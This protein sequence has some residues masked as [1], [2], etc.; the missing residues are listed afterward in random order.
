MDIPQ[1]LYNRKQFRS[2]QQGL[3]KS[4]CYRRYTCPHRVYAPTGCFFWCRQFTAG[5][6]SCRL[7]H[8]L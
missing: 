4:I 8:C 6:N 3:I 1:L 2:Q 7:L 5:F